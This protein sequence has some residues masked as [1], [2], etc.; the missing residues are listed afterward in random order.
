MCPPICLQSYLLMIQTSSVLEKKLSNLIDTANSELKSI[1]SWLNANKMSLNVDKT[2]YMIFRPKSRKISKENDIIINGC[3]ISEVDS[4]KFLGVFIDS[5]LTWQPHIDYISTKISKN[6]GII[7]KARRLFDNE[8]LLTLYYSFIFPYLNYCIHLWGSTF[9]AYL[10]K[11]EILQKKIVRIVAGAK[12]RIIKDNIKI[13]ANTAPLFVNLKILTLKNLYEYNIAFLMYKYHHGW[14]PC[15][16]N[17][18]KRNNEKYGYCT[19]HAEYL[20][21][22]SYSTELGVRSF[23]FQAVRIWNNVYKFLK[24]DIKIGT[25]KKHLKMFLI[26]K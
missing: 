12:K 8:T 24:V 3:R 7:T 16:L 4:T 20:E 13:P 22:P 1:V 5:N 10:S 25:F 15:V 2:H 17:I 19:R 21:V 26:K 9:Q 11:L 6:I 14:L 18:F 23:K